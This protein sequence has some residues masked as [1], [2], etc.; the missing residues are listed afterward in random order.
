MEPEL[1]PN[2]LYIS[3]HRPRNIIGSLIA[4]WTL[5]KYSHTEFIYNGNAYLANPGGVRK[6]K[7]KHKEHF[8]I[9]EIVGFN[10]QEVIDFFQVTEGKPYDYPAIFGSQLFYFL[11]AQDDDKYFCSE[12][13]LNALDYAANY[14]LHW[15]G[16][17]IKEK[18][19]H[20]FNP[21]R[22]YKYLKSQYF[23]KEVK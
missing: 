18:G 5:G 8:D 15:K 1:K 9:Y 3:F 20:K 21:Q 14:K 22:L 16:K 23:I 10:P 12:W 6:Q 7:Y 4:L 11:N 13:C 19:Y 2:F 17:K